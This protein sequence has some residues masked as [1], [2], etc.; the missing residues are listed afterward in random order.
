VS[1]GTIIPPVILRTVLPLVCAVMPLVAFA[2]K[3]PELG[4]YLKFDA[5]PSPAFV[6]GMETE[7]KSIMGPADLR[8]QWIMS[9]QKAR[10]DDWARRIFFHFR[11][12]CN[13]VPEHADDRFA[14]SRIV[15]ADTAASKQ[16]ILPYTE[17]DCDALREF[18][19]PGE[20]DTAGADGRMGRAM[21]RV[22]AHE[23][24]HFLLQT[25]AHSKK[26]IARA[27]HTPAALL[28]R[29]LRFEGGELERIRSSFLPAARL[30]QT[31]Q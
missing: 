6:T 24:Y 23:M 13:A 18:L 14:V 29:S 9:G 19:T 8:L 30:L 20:P 28:G 22:L 31:P 3:A 11:G 21:G 25:R 7:L 10:S 2:Q 16:E 4:L 17:A 1:S 26:G 27:A 15:L 12:T 5:V